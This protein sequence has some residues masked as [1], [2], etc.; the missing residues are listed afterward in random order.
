M[1]ANIAGYLFNFELPDSGTWQAQQDLDG[2]NTGADSLPFIIAEHKKA[3]P[4]VSHA[5]AWDGWQWNSGVKKFDIGNRGFSTWCF[6]QKNTWNF[7]GK[8]RVHLFVKFNKY[9]EVEGG[10]E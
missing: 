5:L 10:K 8:V 9:L 1:I 7:P 2:V 6:V 3:A 4:V